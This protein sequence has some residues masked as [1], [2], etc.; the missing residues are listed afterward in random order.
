VTTY[1]TLILRFRHVLTN[2]TSDTEQIRSSA[3]TKRAFSLLASEA[4]KELIALSESARQI[5]RR[6]LGHF[7][8]FKD[9]IA[10]KTTVLHPPQKPLVDCDAELTF[11]FENSGKITFMLVGHH[12]FRKG[13]K[14]VV[15][16]LVEIR[17]RDGSDFR[18]VIVSRLQRDSY[19]SS[20][21]VDDV[22][23][24]RALINKNGDW[25][26]NYEALSPEGVLEKMQSCDVG[27]LPS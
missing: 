11:P 24:L 3:D 27:L 22:K 21:D 17:C 5:Q 20:S 13:G 1:E 14:D 10:N 26:E 16:A 18:L 8:E 4:C 19:A 12:F 6:F 25:I 9:D 2:H 23:R 7:P 15:D